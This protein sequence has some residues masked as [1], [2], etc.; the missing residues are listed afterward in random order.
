VCA[1][2]SHP[3]T[4]EAARVSRAG[5]HVHTRLNPGGYVWEFGCFAEA[6]VKLEGDAT[7]EFT[8]FAGHMWRIAHCGSCSQHLGWRFDGSD[9]T[10]FG[11]I[12]ERLAVA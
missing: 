4:K 7:L 9:G 12:L 3:V 5:S 8:W 11:L 6:D 1:S 10:F 2:C